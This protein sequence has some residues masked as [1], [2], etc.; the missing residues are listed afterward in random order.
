MFN[1]HEG[2]SLLEKIGVDVEKIKM[3]DPQKSALKNEYLL[4]F[5]PISHNFIS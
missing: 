4:F 5:A 1:C 3:M 2:K